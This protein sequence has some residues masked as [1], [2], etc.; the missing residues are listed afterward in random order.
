MSST[1]P[2]ARA[3][4]VS[5]PPEVMRHIVEDASDWDQLCLDRHPAL[6]ASRAESNQPNFGHSVSALSLVSK[7]WR[8]QTEDLLFKVRVTLTDIDVFR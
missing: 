8:A 2:T 6:A 5:L 3:S 1:S 7:S 4:P